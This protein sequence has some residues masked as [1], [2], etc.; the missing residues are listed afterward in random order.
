MNRLLFLVIPLLLGTACKSSQDGKDDKPDVGTETVTS[1]MTGDEVPVQTAKWDKIA[2]D[3]VASIQ[4]TFSNAEY[5]ALEVSYNP[6][7][8][9]RFGFRD[10]SGMLKE[11][12]A[13]AGMSFPIICTQEM[14]DNGQ[15]PELLGEEL[16]DML[17]KTSRD[18]HY[19]YCND[20]NAVGKFMRAL[21]DGSVTWLQL[22]QFIENGNEP[23]A[24]DF[25][26]EY[27]H[28]IWGTKFMSGEL[29][30]LISTL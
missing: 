27:V 4:T 9:F 5:G 20:E 28:Y 23:S 3:G 18:A 8:G 11:L 29:A 12:T 19:I 2:I 16:M 13:V 6:S 1:M 7:M 15:S 25:G 14:V 22:S 17:P 21:N 10:K 30:E 24:S 26:G